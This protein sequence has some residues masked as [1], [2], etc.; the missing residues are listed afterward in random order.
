MFKASIDTSLTHSLNSWGVSHQFITKL[1][2]QGFLYAA[3]AMALLWIF[4]NARKDSVRKTGFFV[5]ALLILILP[6]IVT[7][8]LATL[9]AGTKNKARPFEAHSDITAV[10]H[11][12]SGH[13]FPAISVAVMA[14]FSIAIH[15]RNKQ[16]GNG[17]MW[18]TVIAGLAQI[19]AGI[20]YPSDMIFGIFLGSIVA[21][22]IKR[23]SAR[24]TQK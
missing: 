1:A 9:L 12:V 21:I 19:A 2:A 23:V 16:A 17:L 22:G 8:G 13:S 6:S 3:V 14:T 11:N 7:Y 18:F 20:H 10:I 15:Q 4:L 24:L 5:D